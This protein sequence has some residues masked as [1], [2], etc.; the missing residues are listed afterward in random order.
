[1]NRRSHIEDLTGRVFGRLTVLRRGENNKSGNPRWLCECSCSARTQILAPGSSLRAGTSQ[2]CGCLAREN[3]KALMLGNKRAF[4]HG[5]GS[6]AVGLSPVYQSWKHMMERC[7]NPNHVAWLH[8]G[9]TNPPVLVCERWL[10]FE[11]FLADM[12]ERPTNTSLGRFGDVGNYSCGHCEQCHANGWEL[13][14][15]WQTDQEQKAEQK[16]KK[17]LKFLSVTGDTN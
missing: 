13:N 3:G 17:Q 8:Y 11:N 16:I 4:K 10:V 7:T 6:Y 14:C 12:G 5:H 9:G 15:E 2:S 1:V